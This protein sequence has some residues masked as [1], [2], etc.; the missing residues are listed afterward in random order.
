MNFRHSKF[1]YLFIEVRKN[2]I[3]DDDETS[4]G[5]ANIRQR[6]TEEVVDITLCREKYETLR[7]H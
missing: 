7:K 6:C 1:V 3:V 5:L 2:V 4:S